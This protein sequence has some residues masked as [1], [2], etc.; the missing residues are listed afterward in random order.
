[1]EAQASRIHA[2]FGWPVPH[3]SW[4]LHDLFIKS[5]ILELLDALCNEKP[6]SKSGVLYYGIEG[7]EG[8][9]GV[10]SGAFI[11]FSGLVCAHALKP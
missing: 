11:S 7:A 3:H 10:C 5:G 2:P 6:P 1:M 4:F 9:K 8:N